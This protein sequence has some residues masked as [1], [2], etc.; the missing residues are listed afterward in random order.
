MSR[1]EIPAHW[2]P[3]QVAAY[4]TVHEYADRKA[5]PKGPKGAA[6]LGPKMGKSAATLSNE[7]S[8]DVP[9]HKYGL[10]DSITVQLLTGDYRQLHAYAA[11]LHHVAIALPDFD[12]VSDV[13]LLN[14]FA[15]W[16]A[17]LGRTCQEIHKSLAD[18]Q[19]DPI[20]LQQVK[21][22]GFAHIAKFFQ[23]LQR[24]E[25]IAEPGDE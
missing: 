21:A 24:M 13:E 17:A 12:T 7:V 2:T 10:E 19:V 5:G 25:Q 23:F 11:E 15:E 16:Q 6:A 18:G 8:P 22:K 9:T 1:S 20:E 14:Q 3:I 4:R